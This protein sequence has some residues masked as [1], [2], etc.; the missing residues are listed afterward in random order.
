MINYLK[1]D[2][3]DPIKKPAIIVHVCNNK[4]GWGKGFVLALSAKW[5]EPEAAYREWYKH[6]GD[7]F[8][9]KHV[10]DVECLFV[11]SKKFKLGS[12]QLVRVEKDLWV[13]NMIAQDGFKRKGDPEGA[14]YLTYGSLKTALDRVASF[15]AV[16]SDGITIHMPRRGCGLAGGT[17]D[18]VEEVLESCKL[19]DVY[20]YDFD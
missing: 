18:T 10:L 20:V 8:D 17:W 19:P 12:V 15:A 3:T 16:V 13:A 1:G 9:D 11:D 5:K 7:S 6:R 14:V 2:A 4:G